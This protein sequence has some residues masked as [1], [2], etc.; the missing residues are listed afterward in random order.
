LRKLAALRNRFNTTRIFA[1]VA[2]ILKHILIYHQKKIVSLSPRELFGIVG[3]EL[4]KRWH[5]IMGE[6]A[7]C[8]SGKRSHFPVGR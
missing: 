2:D 6:P 5:G 8:S 7:F 3:E 4:G 1:S